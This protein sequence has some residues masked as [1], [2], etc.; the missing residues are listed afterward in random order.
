MSDNISELVE[1][2]TKSGIDPDKAALA[3]AEVFIAGVTIGN[4]AALEEVIPALVKMFEAGVKATTFRK[5]EPLSDW[6]ATVI[7]GGRN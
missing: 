1:T 2:L 4:R 6:Q 7:P 5:P 3:A